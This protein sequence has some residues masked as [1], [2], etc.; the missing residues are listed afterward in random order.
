MIG[1]T[2]RAKI[3]FA[4]LTCSIISHLIHS[5]SISANHLHVLLSFPHSQPFSRRLCI[6]FLCTVEIFFFLLEF[7]SWYL[8]FN[9]ASPSLFLPIAFCTSLTD[10]HLEPS[11]LSSHPGFRHNTMELP[12]LPD[13]L[14]A[15]PRSKLCSAKEHPTYQRSGG[16]NPRG[17][18]GRRTQT[19]EHWGN[20]NHRQG[21]GSC[22][23]A[24][25]RPL[26]TL[27]SPI[28]L[29]PFPKLSLTSLGVLIHLCRSVK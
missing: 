20:H 24:R 2:L 10:A 18:C 25:R 8:T 27:F 16:R 4:Y 21:Y 5:I 1:V 22:T 6:G 29:I 19:A 11:V 9:I 14:P 23:G 17:V 26:T 28:F 13:N 3:L 7:F 12:A 15:Q